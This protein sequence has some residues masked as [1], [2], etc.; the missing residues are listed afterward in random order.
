VAV[1]RFEFEGSRSFSLLS[2]V[3][4]GGIVRVVACV[5]AV[6]DVT[7]RGGGEADDDGSDGDDS[8][9][10]DCVG[11]EYCEP[12]EWLRTGGGSSVGMGG[13]IVATV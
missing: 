11:M 2:K 1:T 6:G 5:A 10:E 9:S 4:G 13:G 12:C 7:S 3:S 8:G